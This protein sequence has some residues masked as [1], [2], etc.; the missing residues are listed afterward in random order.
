M[1]WICYNFYNKLYKTQVYHFGNKELQ[2]KVFNFFP[3]NFSQGMNKKFV[4]PLS[5]ENFKQQ[6]TPWKKTRPQDLIAWW[7]SSTPSSKI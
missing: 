3:I 4:A 7:W 2:H 6:Q 1:E 5:L